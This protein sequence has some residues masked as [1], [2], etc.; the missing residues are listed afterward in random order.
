SQPLAAIRNYAYALK[1]SLSLRP[2][3]SEHRAIADRLGEETERAME[4]VRKSAAWVLKTRMKW[5]CATSTRRYRT[6][7]GS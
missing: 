2:A 7:C 1:V 6:R 5:A 4:V 3:S